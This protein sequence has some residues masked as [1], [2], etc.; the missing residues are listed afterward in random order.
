MNNTKMVMKMVLSEQGIL[1][2]IQKMDAR[3]T[4]ELLADLRVMREVEQKMIEGM[5]ASFKEQ[6]KTAYIH[7][8]GLSFSLILLGEMDGK[9]MAKELTDD[10]IG[11]IDSFEFAVEGT[12]NYNHLIWTAEN[13][14]DKI[15]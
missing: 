8:V 11:L 4:P 7:S 9:D 12:E 3:I 13:I 6:G 14:Y 2:Q 5:G 1:K 10:M 15:S